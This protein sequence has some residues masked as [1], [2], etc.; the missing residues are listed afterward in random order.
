MTQAEMTMS[1]TDR[2]GYDISRC[3]YDIGRCD[4]EI[5]R[6]GYG[7]GRC[8]YDIGRY[9][10]G[11]VRGCIWHSQRLHMTQSEVA[12]DI[13]RLILTYT[14]LPQTWYRFSYTDFLL[15]L[16]R[17]KYT[18]TSLPRISNLFSTIFKT[19]YSTSKLQM[20]IYEYLFITAQL[21]ASK[22]RL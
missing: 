14:R 19:K 21:C 9:G 16:Q 18:Y 7:K 22:T 6:D 11:I 3:G 5:G 17:L 13:G 8:G 2:C 10:Y 12:H 1:Q 20:A 15:L 4:Y